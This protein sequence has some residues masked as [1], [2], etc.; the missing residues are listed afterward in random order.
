M[1]RC[2]RNNVIAMADEERIG[3][4]NESSASELGHARECAVDLRFG[5]SA[6][7]LNLHPK[8]DCSCLHIF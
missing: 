4:D 2:E 6:K 3:G 8:C 5:G 1:A 7:D